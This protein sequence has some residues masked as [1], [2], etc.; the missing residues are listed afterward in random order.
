VIYT[1]AL[2]FVTMLLF[3]ITIVVPTLLLCIVAGVVL[4]CAIDLGIRAAKCL[5]NCFTRRGRP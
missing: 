5:F 3:L 2:A 1:A 4:L